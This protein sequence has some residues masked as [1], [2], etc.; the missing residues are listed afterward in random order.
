MTKTIGAL[1]LLAT[2]ACAAEPT[3]ASDDALSSAN[4]ADEATAALI[5]S[6]YDDAH[7]YFREA[8][9]DDDKPAGYWISAEAYDAV[10]DA[11]QRDGIK[12]F[13][14]IVGI[15]YDDQ[16]K[17]GWSSDF[18]DDESWM[19]M[20]LI[21][22]WDVT[23]ESRYL[24]RAGSLFSDIDQNGRTSTG[25]W[26]NRQHVEMATA[27][28]FGPAIVA[29]RLFERTGHGRYKQV[30]TEIYDTWYA[31][32]VDDATGQVADHRDPDGHKD[33]TEWT[34]NN[35]LA[36]AAALEV[37]H[38]TGDKKYLAQAYRF[39]DWMVHHQ[40]IG[41]EYGLI[42]HDDHCT[43]D[44]DAFKGIAF[45]YLAKLYE[46]DR[47]NAWYHAVLSNSAKA[48]WNLAQNGVTRTFAPS[49]AGPT[50]WRTTLGADASAVMA[51]NIA[52]EDGL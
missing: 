17:R 24:D 18:F 36:I 2:A 19:A 33:W 13:H 1:L 52:A 15:V 49:W 43:G 31:A 48:I 9:P 40:T 22:A 51:L 46:I 47:S 45:R 3:G 29:A 39:G 14:A 8:Y 42:L 7:G 5:K 11:L 44:C 28:N 38:I 41:S 37:F 12:D 4:R 6:F 27:S 23:H 20:A 30:A 10:L 32:M 21:R 26:W 50:Q 25:V 34:Y 16:S 35:G